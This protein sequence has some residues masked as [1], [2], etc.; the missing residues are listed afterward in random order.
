MLL[1][2]YPYVDVWSLFD[3][4]FD[5]YTMAF[6]DVCYLSATMFLRNFNMHV[7][8]FLENVMSIS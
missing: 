3:V 1:R 4:V 2:L 8:R 6:G 5:I 7:W